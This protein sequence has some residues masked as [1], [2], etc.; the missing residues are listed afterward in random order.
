M[1]DFAA[2]LFLLLLPVV[3]LLLA[4]LRLRRRAVFP[5]GY[6]PSARSRASE[7]L[8][9]SLRL[10]Y[11]LLL[12]ALAAILVAL[13]L[14]GWP[15]PGPG[16]VAAVLDGSRSMIRGE[17]GS[18]GVDR[19]VRALYE[20]EDLTGARVF[21]LDFDPDR[22][23]YRLRDF[24]RHRRED[25]PEEFAARVARESEALGADWRI[26]ASLRS[27]GYGRIVAFTDSLPRDPEGF[28][29]VETGFS[30]L[31]YAYPA[32]AGYE[33]A[34]ESWALRLAVEGE[35][36]GLIVHRWEE[37]A[38]AFARLATD[39]LDL[40]EGPSGWILRFPRPGLVVVAVGGESYPV[41]LPP[42]PARPEGSGT[43][44]RAMA[45]VFTFLPERPGEG[46]G[47][48]D[49]RRPRIGP[50]VVTSLGD[51]DT[52]LVEDP[53]EA[54]GA[55]VPLAEPDA[56]AGRADVALGRG[57]LDSPDLP[58]LYWNRLQSS[59]PAPYFAGPE[60]AGPGWK[61]QGSGYWRLGRAGPEALL[62]PIGE[63]APSVRTGSLRIPEREYRRWPIAAALA[64]LYTLKLALKRLFS[65]SSEKSPGRAGRSVP[66]PESLRPPPGAA[67]GRTP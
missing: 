9:R 62:P 14:S 21:L 18:R 39:S 6:F 44:S 48:L 41:L 64:L 61:P 59:L 65:G 60:P 67:P 11:D 49:S 1:A 28:E 25:G 3:L 52:P 51:A 24:T 32:S 26:L 15:S 2:R 46:L 34:T 55:L 31:P 40:A 33:D 53:A 16:R 10:R 19:A 12:D 8:L 63:Y 27:R 38:G 23:E 57:S 13:A 17:P 66:K 58:L 47:F 36:S 4:G 43:F 50:S 37:A 56:R 22:G 42:R 45:S 35:P 20:R 54:Y 7:V 5:H 29:A 30:E